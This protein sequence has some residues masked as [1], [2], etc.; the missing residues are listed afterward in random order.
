[1]TDNLEYIDRFFNGELSPEETQ[2][3]EKRIIDDPE[4]ADEVTFYLSARQ[5]LQEEVIKE[6]KERFRQL[7]KEDNT[8]SKNFQTGRVRKLWMYNV[9]AAAAVIVFAFFAWYLFFSKA[10]SP[11]QLADNYIN[12]NL[13]T[14]SVTMGI[15][16]DSIQ[17]GL[18]LYNEGQYDS[19]LQQ[20]ETIIYRD[21]ANYLAKKYA[22]IVYLKLNNY[23]KALD[24][25]RQPEKFS[26][27]SNPAKFYQSL[28]LLKR[29]LPG[30]KQQAKLLLKK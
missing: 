7:L 11:Q 28:T 14:L 29:D 12:G 26:L 6:K 22:G 25:F 21:T 17:T 8:F 9:A 30:D 16:K 20:F 10:S 3:F 4:F 1:M 27:F 2:H 23:D 5:I 19:A 24:Y 18:H 13:K 15:E